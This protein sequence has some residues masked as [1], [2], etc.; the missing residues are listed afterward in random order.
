MHKPLPY[1]LALIGFLAAG[2]APQTRAVTVRLAEFA[3]EPTTVE[4][5]AGE[6]IAITIVNDGVVEH[7]FVVDALPHHG[8]SLSGAAE[9]EH[10]DMAMDD[11]DVHAAVAAGT[12]AVLTFTP[13]QAGEYVIY[14]SV[15]GHRESGMTAELLVR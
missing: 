15:A 6:P 10:G 11:G 8:L 14:C 7:D 5:Q 2:C 12:T 3:F 13:D 1:V 9:M 4:A